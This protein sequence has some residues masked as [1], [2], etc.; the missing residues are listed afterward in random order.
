MAFE[1]I[2]QRIVI[3][4][5]LGCTESSPSALFAHWSETWSGL[6]GVPVPGLELKLSRVGQ[7]LEARYRGP[8]VTP[9]Y[10]REPD[11][12]RA[13]FDDEGFY[14]TGDALRFVDERHPNRGMLFDGRIAEDFKL[15]T[16]TWVS[17]GPLRATVI[18]ACA[19]LVADVVLTGLD[20]DS[21]GAILFPVWPECRRLAGLPD[22]APGA[23]VVAHPEVRRYLEEALARCAARGTGSASRVMRAL[24]TPVPPSTD[25]GEIT[26]KGSLNQRT[27]LDRRGS[28]VESLHATPPGESVL[29]IGRSAE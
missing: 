25:A 10:F 20:R 27:V 23:K 16:G 13:A 26:D 14:R 4:S 28:L 11:A 24:L 3:T 6:L 2:G 12:T 9:G 19:P 21:V 17:V 7:K 8:N 29:V 15:D 5:G 1:T 22:D 18:E